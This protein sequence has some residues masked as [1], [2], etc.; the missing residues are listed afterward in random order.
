[1]KIRNIVWLLALVG[2]MLTGCATGPTTEELQAALEAEKAKAVTLAAAIEAESDKQE[3][4][5]DSLSYHQRNNDIYRKHVQDAMDERDSSQEYSQV[6]TQKYNKLRDDLEETE[7]KRQQIPTMLPRLSLYSY[8]PATTLPDAI[9]ED[10]IDQE[11]AVLEALETTLDAM[12]KLEALH[13]T[14]EDNYRALH[15]ILQEQYNAMVT[16]GQEDTLACYDLDIKWK[17]AWDALCLSGGNLYE[18]QNEHLRD[19]IQEMEEAIHHY[20][21]QR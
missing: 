5:Q 18:S 16:A 20:E 10:T 6:M 19:Y 15:T 1:M 7:Y 2:L 21:N 11:K 9:T 8:Y 17:A 14:Q 3:S 12:E 4:L 13:Q